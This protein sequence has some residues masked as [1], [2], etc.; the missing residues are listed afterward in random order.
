[1]MREQ[2]LAD[3]A[4][5]LVADLYELGGGWADSLLP[6]I[7]DADAQWVHEVCFCTAMSAT[8]PAGTRWA[9]LAV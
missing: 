4:I 7:E 6:A 3:L 9:V 1:M 5:R 8:R 2:K